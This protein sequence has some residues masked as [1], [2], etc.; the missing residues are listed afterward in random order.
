MNHKRLK[1]LQE[2]YR[3]AERDGMV[4]VGIPADPSSGIAM[5]WCWAKRLSSSY[6]RLANFCVCG[7][8]INFGDVVEFSE[9]PEPDV[10]LKEFVRVVSRGSEQ[11]MVAY[12]TRDEV[13]DASESM[14]EQ[15]RQRHREILQYLDDF[16][17]TGAVLAWE[18]TEPGLLCIALPVGTTEEEVDRLLSCCPHLVD[19]HW[20]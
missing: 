18:G 13:A 10:I 20:L 11:A 2:I 7:G 5:E 8:G 3:R 12:A 4:K 14:R 17:R 16:R 9:Q 1:E 6:A 15:I 19:P